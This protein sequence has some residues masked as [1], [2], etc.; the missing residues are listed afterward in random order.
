MLECEQ[1][2]MSD[3]SVV[4]AVSNAL[5]ADLGII[6]A[7]NHLMAID[8]NKICRQRSKLHQ[9]SLFDMN[10]PTQALFFLI[11]KNGRKKVGGA[12][13]IDWFAYF[14]FSGSFISIC[15]IGCDGAAANAGKRGGII[16]FIENKHCQ[17]II[18]LLHKRF[19][20]APFFR[21]I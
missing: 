12:H 8:R 1:F 19:T 20:F 16:H 13:N 7:G 21:L 3:R 15:A 2:Q 9:K 14:F 5:L 17:W 4:A 18:C 6:C 11:E 10:Q